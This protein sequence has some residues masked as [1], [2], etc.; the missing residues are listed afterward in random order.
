MPH[1]IRRVPDSGV[2]NTTDLLQ[3]ARAGDEQALEELFARHVPL[4][5]R[6]ASG[7]LPR[8]ARD[9]TD[10][11]DLVQETAVA[12]FKRLD[13]F[14]PRGEGALQAYLRQAIVNR[15]RSQIRN[16]RARPE[17]VELESQIPD[18][19]TSPLEAAIGQQTVEQYE[20][21]LN[22]LTPEERDAIVSRVEFGLS[23]AEVAEVLGKPS[24]DAARMAVVRALVRL[25]E[26]MGRR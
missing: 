9:I 16:R 5:K 19:G 4:L 22:R 20:A 8:W 23:F 21:G 10:T 13:A 25:A 1:E 24:P 11:S 12:T 18:E 2:D 26:E 17:A 6:W 3:R 14:E 7:R 15:I